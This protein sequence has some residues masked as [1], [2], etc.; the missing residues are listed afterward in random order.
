MLIGGSG[1]GVPAGARRTQLLGA[2]SARL[3]ALFDNPQQCHCINSKPWLSA[4]NQQRIPHYHRAI[5][6]GRGSHDVR[7]MRGKQCTAANP[8]RGRSSAVGFQRGSGSVMDKFIHRES[9]AL[10]RKRLAG[11]GLTDDQRQAIL[12]LLREEHTRGH[13]TQPRERITSGEP[14][15][16][17]LSVGRP[18]RGYLR[19]VPLTRRASACLIHIKEPPAASRY[20]RC[21]DSTT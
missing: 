2:K 21:R 16:T 12:R 19:M 17:H 13:Q 3:T 18:A 1:D 4:A 9:S 10:G 15:H 7:G 6:C 5:D 20:S 14:A 11:P 8:T